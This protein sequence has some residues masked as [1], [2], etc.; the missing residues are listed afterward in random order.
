[1]LI[2][3]NRPYAYRLYGFYIFC[4]PAILPFDVCMTVNCIRKFECAQKTYTY[5][6]HLTFY[7]LHEIYI[8]TSSIIILNYIYYIIY[9]YII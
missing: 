3:L 1:M 2:I 7:I 6:L 8:L 4:H 9:K 5:N